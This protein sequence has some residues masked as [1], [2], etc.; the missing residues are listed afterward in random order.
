MVKKLYPL[1]IH[2]VGALKGISP[3]V[4][5]CGKGR[6]IFV[7]SLHHDP[8]VILDFPKR[9]SVCIHRESRA[10]APGFARDGER[11]ESGRLLTIGI[12]CPLPYLVLKLDKLTI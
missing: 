10:Q 6:N 3:D 12:T 4:R 9:R 7:E 2:L 8:A 5:W 1:L 11:T